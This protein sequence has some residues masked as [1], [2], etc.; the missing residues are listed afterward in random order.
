V[1]KIAQF[2]FDLGWEAANQG[3]E[4]QWLQGDEFEAI[5]KAS[6][7]GSAAQGTH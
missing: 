5:R 2:G 6:L 7:S 1:A 4:V 3:R